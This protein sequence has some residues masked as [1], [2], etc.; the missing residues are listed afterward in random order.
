LDTIGL[1]ILADCGADTGTPKSLFLDQTKN[2]TMTTKAN[3]RTS[4]FLTFI[5]F[6]AASFFK[7]VFSTRISTLKIVGSRP[8]FSLKIVHITR[9][10]G[11]S[12]EIRGHKTISR[13]EIWSMWTIF[14]V[15]NRFMWTISRV[16][17]WSMWTIFQGWKLG[18]G[19]ERGPGVKIAVCQGHPRS[20][21]TQKR[22]DQGASRPG[23]PPLFVFWA[24]WGNLGW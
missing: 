12:L 5:A 6:L 23:P 9:F 2:T 14:R 11:V 20:P 1:G 24:S 8:L 13:V 7:T 22:G 15:G 16:E 4:R 21:K 3:E 10:S 17:I 18:K 19:R